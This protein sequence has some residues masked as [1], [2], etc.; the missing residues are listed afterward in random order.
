[1][2]FWERQTYGDSKK[3]MV[4]RDLEKKGG[5]ERRKMR[6]WSTKDF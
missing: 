3:I 6:R 5:R 1:M 2:T 4:A